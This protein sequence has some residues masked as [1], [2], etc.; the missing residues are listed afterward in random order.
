MIKELF[1]LFFYIESVSRGCPWAAGEAFDQHGRLHHRR[2]SRA[3][4]RGVG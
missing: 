1:P 3:V 2:G 4:E